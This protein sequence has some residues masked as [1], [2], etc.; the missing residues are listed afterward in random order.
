MIEHA[1]EPVLAEEAQLGRLKESSI[2]LI[3]RL[4]DASGAYPASPTFSAYKGYSW[5]RDG[6]FI[7][8]AVSAAGEIDSATRFFDWCG[9]ILDSRSSTIAAMIERFDAGQPVADTEM[10]PARFTFD[11]VEGDDD[12]WDFQL[13][14]YGTWLWAVAEH[15]RRHGLS[16][17]RWQDAIVLT[18]DYLERFWDRPCYD[19]WEE[20]PEK[21]HVSTLGCISAGL[22]AVLDVLDEPRRALAKSA[23]ERIRDLVVAEGVTAGH[24]AKWLGSTEVDASL[25]AV[26]YPLN[27]FPAS[28]E[29]GMN[30]VRAVDDQLSEVGGVHRYLADTFYGGGQ[31][32]LLSCMLGLAWNASGDRTRALDLLR[33]AAATATHDGYLP[34]QVGTHLLA[35]AS[36]QEWI[37]RW[38][39]V[40][41]P[42]LWSHAMFIRL[43]VELGLEGGERE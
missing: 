23:V 43:A 26:V 31:W 40:A 27:V 16:L 17:D 10:L 15:A 8:D 1:S 11:G 42:L 5:F 22:S 30:T 20:H 2:R 13:D 33:S 19:W 34:E 12:W 38:G 4:Q 37:D 29:I 9:R 25:A 35:P 21:R 36:E 24:L 3:L 18:V 7:A 28:E 6:A 32:P 39:T 14:G 41:T